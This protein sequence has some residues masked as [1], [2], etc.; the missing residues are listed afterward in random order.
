MLWAN[1]KTDDINIIKAMQ[2]QAD[3]TIT[4]VLDN[5]KNFVD[6]YSLIGFNESYQLMK[7]I[8]K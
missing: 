7:K 3:F 8:C 4:A 6:T 1:N 5:A 2:Q